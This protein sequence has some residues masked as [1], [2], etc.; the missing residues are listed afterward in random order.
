MLML[1]K[2][3]LEER[4]MNSRDIRL[5]GQESNGGVWAISK[6]NLL[7]HDIPDADVRNEDTLAAPQHTEDGELMRFDRVIH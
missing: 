5:Y 1:S 2:E 7:L 4:R 6:M 3:Y